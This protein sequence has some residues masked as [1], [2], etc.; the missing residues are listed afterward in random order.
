[1]TASENTSGQGNAAVIPPEIDRWNWGAFLLN[2]I[3]GIGNGTYI[4]LLT[5]VPL[6]GLVM[7]FVLGAKG[8]AWAWRNRKWDG[9]AH[10]KRV[11][12]LWAIWGCIVLAA[13]VILAVAIIFLVMSVLKGSEAYRLGVEALNANARAVE[14]LGPPVTAGTPS[15]KIEVSGSE[16]EAGLSFGVSGSK[17]HG[18][19]VLEATKHLGSWTLDRGAE[20]ILP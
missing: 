9:V 13:T 4:A 20:A 2:W 19:I 15:G 5:L 14:L 6:V 1:M 10:F 8:S 18:T 11:Q 12:R 17:A 7:I 16:G 3:W